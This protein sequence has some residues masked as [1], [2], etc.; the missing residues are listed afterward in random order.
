[1]TIAYNLEQVLQRIAKSVKKFRNNG[2]DVQLVAV[3]KTKP[4]EAIR[5]AW[6]QG[7]KVFGESYVQE[8]VDKIEQ[9]NNCD[10]EWHF[11]GPIQ[12]NK[13]SAIARHF[14]WCQ[15][16]DRSKIAR[17]LSSQRPD[18]L[19]PLN[20]CIQL[21]I[22]SEPSK[23]GTDLEAL[24]PL[25]E[26]IAALP[27]LTLRGLMTI[28]ERQ[29]D[30]E[31]QRKVFAAM[32]DIYNELKNRFDTVDTLSMGMSNDLEAAIA[33]GSTMVRIGTD[34]FGARE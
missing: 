8:A 7:Q 22:S 6:E 25:A 27:N 34:I 30:F 10:I 4:V 9:L 18:E 5:M 14:N 11:I 20:I 24:W 26:E 17:R 31:Q 13:T 16:V 28:P 1:M 2:D 12:S 23:S 19:P 15:S 33:E 29:P 3:S 21:N 32:H